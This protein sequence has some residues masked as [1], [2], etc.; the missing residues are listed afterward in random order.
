MF[1]CSVVCKCNELVGLPPTQPV[2]SID[3]H[4][5]STVSSRWIDSGKPH[6]LTSVNRQL[7]VKDQN[8]EVV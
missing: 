5:A 4:S 2:D 8:V 6:Y 1:F 7:K 3:L